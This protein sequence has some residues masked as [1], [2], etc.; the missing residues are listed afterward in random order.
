MHLFTWHV[1]PSAC[2][3]L[4]SQEGTDLIHSGTGSCGTRTVPKT[5]MTLLRRW[6]GLSQ[7]QSHLQR[8]SNH[9]KQFPGPT[10]SH[11]EKGSGRLLQYCPGNQILPGLSTSKS[12]KAAEPPASPFPAPCLSISYSSSVSTHDCLLQEACLDEHTNPVPLVSL[13]CLRLLSSI[14][15]VSSP[16]AYKFA[17]G[18]DLVLDA[19]VPFWPQRGAYREGMEC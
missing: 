6:A 8:S 10:Q 13:V 4:N 16:A 15:P 19:F 12:C 17:K 18:Q 2:S 11:V 5:K 14:R 9:F 1:G 3:G 7:R